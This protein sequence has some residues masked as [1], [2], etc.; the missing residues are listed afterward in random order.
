MAMTL[1]LDYTSKA[2]LAD[3]SQPTKVG[4]ASIT[5]CLGGQKSELTEFEDSVVDPCHCV[6]FVS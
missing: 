3:F 6:F 2:A 1:S 5:S 4:G